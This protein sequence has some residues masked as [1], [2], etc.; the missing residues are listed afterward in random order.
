MRRNE[1]EPEARGMTTFRPMRH[2]LLF[3]VMTALPVMA[4][5][6]G[7]SYAHALQP[8]RGYGSE[9]SAA[10][11]GELRQLGVDSVALMPFGFQRGERD[12][13]ILWVGNRGGRG[14]GIGETDEAMRAGAR[15]ARAVGM[16][17]MLKPHLW[18]RQPQWPGSIDH[19]TDAEWE[20]WFAAYTPFALHYA[21]L[22]EEI[23]AE[24]F[25]I[26]NELT[27]SVK[28]E[29][30]WRMLIAETRKLYHGRLTYGANL[31][32]VYDVPFWDALDVI[33]ISAY[34]PLS[35]EDSPSEAALEK[36]WA[37]IVA[38]LGKLSARLRR[39]VLFTELGY[40]SRDGAAA[41]PWK[42]RGSRLNTEVQAA[43][44]DAFFH[45]VWPQRWFAGV[46]FWKWESYPEHDDG[47]HIA[48][49][50]EHKPAA[51]VV[52]RYFEGLGP[53]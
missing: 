39:P 8:N 38:K 7:M 15:Q 12:T 40:S 23:H 27:H 6:K 20:A 22:A 49:S 41:E 1:A 42:E 11:L 51:E 37:P 4:K 2:A 46:Y 16:R 43:A 17:V 3:L 18:L 32:E 25:C 13:E 48:Y 30:R 10:S 47:T 21:A 26:G 33:G 50:I 52:R 28:Q 9:A 53:R 45:A 14:G 5:D 31:D 29:K 34:F 44:Y 35:Q 36:G 19:A 24:T